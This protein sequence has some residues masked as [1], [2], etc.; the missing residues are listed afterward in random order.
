MAGL[1]LC[2]LLAPTIVAADACRLADQLALEKRW[3]L[4]ELEYRRVLIENADTSVQSHAAL[5]VTRALR[6]TRPL[7]EVIAWCEQQRPS[8]PTSVQDEVILE[9]AR[10]A[11]DYRSGQFVYG[12]TGPISNAGAGRALLLRA[13]AASQSREFR[14]AVTELDSIPPES[15][16]FSVAK[17]FRLRIE[18]ERARAGLSSR[19]AAWLNVIPGCG[20]AYAHAPQTA[21]SAF[22]VNGVFALATYQAFHHDQTALGWFMGAVTFSWYAGGIYGAYLTAGRVNRFHEDEFLES[23]P[24]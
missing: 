20:Y 23:L 8:L 6:R 15:P 7:P 13:I 4:A 16:S 18:G 5:G 14:L 2:L 22:I 9:T 19:A 21:V 17:D 10:A 24:Y 12:I 11:L 3:D 1:C